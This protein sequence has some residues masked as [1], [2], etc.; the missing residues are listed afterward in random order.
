MGKTG[1]SLKPW[2]PPQFASTHRIPEPQLLCVLLTTQQK[3]VLR[4]ERRRSAKATK[5]GKS[6]GEPSS[7]WGLWS[8]SFLPLP[9]TSLPA[10]RAACPTL[11]L[12]SIFYPR[13]CP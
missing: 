1:G 11:S 10:S 5:K 2:L 4:T 3:F 6:R 8:T 7:S 13:L 9:D 12:T